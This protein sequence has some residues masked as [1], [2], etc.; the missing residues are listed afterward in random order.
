MGSSNSFKVQ[1]RHEKNSR[2]L[3]NTQGFVYVSGTGCRGKDILLLFVE[4]HPAFLVDTSQHPKA[5][6]SNSTEQDV[7]AY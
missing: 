5:Y 7:Q 2:Q 4:K 6:H 1:G 3:E